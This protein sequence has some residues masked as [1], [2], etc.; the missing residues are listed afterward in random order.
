MKCI[1]DC[2]EK[3]SIKGRQGSGEHDGTFS[4]ALCVNIA[5]KHLRVRPSSG[6]ASKRKTPNSAM[7]PTNEGARFR[8][9]DAGVLFRAL[10]TRS[11]T[12][13]GYNMQP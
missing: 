7:N 10:E 2:A 11:R 3:G 1:V 4:A 9:S 5:T 13:S 6:K 8:F 12:F